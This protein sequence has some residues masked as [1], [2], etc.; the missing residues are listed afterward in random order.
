MILLLWILLTGF[1][2]FN[3]SNLGRPKLI[4]AGFLFKFEYA[5]SITKDLEVELTRLNVELGISFPISMPI[6]FNGIPC[7]RLIT[8]CSREIDS[9]KIKP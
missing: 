3:K 8:T 2:G 6:F 5:R 1:I 7:Q 4:K 9:L